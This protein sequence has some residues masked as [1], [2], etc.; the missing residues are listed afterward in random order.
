MNPNDTGNIFFNTFMPQDGDQNFYTRWVAFTRTEQLAIAGC[1][2]LAIL[3]YPERVQAL[4]AD[5]R[6]ALM[7]LSNEIED[8]VRS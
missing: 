2:R 8:V 1:L 5:M 7:T 6:N 3:M 4:N